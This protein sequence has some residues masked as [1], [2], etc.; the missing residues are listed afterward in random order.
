MKKE[1]F[2]VI[3]F[4]R[5]FILTIDKELDNFP[6]KDIE[7]KNRIRN[8]SYDLLELAYAANTTKN[9]EKKQ[10]ILEIIITKIKVIDFLL[11]LCYDKEIINHKKYIKLGEK[12]NDIIKYTIGWT[13][14]VKQ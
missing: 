7:L 3:E 2:Q 10:E 11:N 1:K 14:S 6:K 13:K 9:N 8:S 4:I 5:Q 12:M